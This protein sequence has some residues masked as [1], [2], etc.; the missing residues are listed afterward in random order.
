MSILDSSLKTCVALCCTQRL[1]AQR[2]V[3]ISVQL[4]AGDVRFEHGL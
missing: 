4:T 3:Y 2:H 1:R